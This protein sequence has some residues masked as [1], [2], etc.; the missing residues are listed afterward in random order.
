M[1]VTM[2]TFKCSARAL[3][4]WLYFSSTYCSQWSHSC[5]WGL[6]SLFVSYSSS[7][8]YVS[9]CFFNSSL[10]PSLYVSLPVSL[11]T[12]CLSISPCFSLFL[13]TRHLLVLYLFLCFV[14]HFL[15]SIVSWWCSSSDNKTFQSDASYPGSLHSLHTKEN[16]IK[17]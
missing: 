4:C 15:L 5:E 6:H 13:C 12:M 14:S 9:S 10:S 7:C 3:Y 8:L 2:R 1:V 17:C 11:F 16:E